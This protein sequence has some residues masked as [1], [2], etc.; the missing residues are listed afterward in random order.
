[1]LHRFCVLELSLSLRM[2]LFFAYVRTFI[3][4]QRAQRLQLKYEQRCSGTGV[5]TWNA[6]GP[7]IASSNEK[8]ECPLLL[9]KDTESRDSEFNVAEGRW[10]ICLATSFE[11]WFVYYGDGE[12]APCFCFSAPF[13]GLSLLL[14]PVM[15]T[16][17]GINAV[18]PSG[19]L[20]LELLNYC[21]RK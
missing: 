2:F 11:K 10:A 19:D 17:V 13:S 9:T 18:T 16:G 4:C 1:M 5:R 3:G 21:A 7:S 12:Y 15:Y 8:R 14:I 6:R 20:S